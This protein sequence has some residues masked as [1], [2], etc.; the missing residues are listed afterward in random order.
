M[1]RSRTPWIKNRAGVER[2]AEVERR[3]RHTFTQGGQ[4]GAHGR[5][6]PQAHE[7]TVLLERSPRT[8]KPSP[9]T[10]ETAKAVPA[11]RLIVLRE[12]PGRQLRQPAAMLRGMPGWQAR[13]PA[14]ERLLESFQERTGEFT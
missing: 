5:Q 8:Q 14:R 3:F 10:D 1:V 11:G 2:L 13:Q 7:R 12:D 4:R 9:L 6:L